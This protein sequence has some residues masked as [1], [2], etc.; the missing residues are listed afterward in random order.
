[1]SDHE[2]LRQVS[3]DRLA[4]LVFELAAQLHVERTQ[5]LALETVLAR[6]G[7]IAP[8]APEALADDPALLAVAREKLDRSIR[9]LLRIVTETGDAKAPLRP[10]ALP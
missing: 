8:G 1:M 4:A 10:E 3:P 6:A 2:Y 9:A 7:V 5:R